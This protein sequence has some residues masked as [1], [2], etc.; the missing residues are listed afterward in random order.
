MSVFPVSNGLSMYLQ[1]KVTVPPSALWMVCGP[2]DI[3]FSP[4]V[5]V[6]SVQIQTIS[7]ISHNKTNIA[8]GSFSY[9][10][11]VNA[12]LFLIHWAAACFHAPWRTLCRLFLF[13]QSVS[14]R[15]NMANKISQIETN[16][17]KKMWE[18][19]YK[20]FRSCKVN[21]YLSRRCNKKL[22]VHGAFCKASF[23]QCL[24]YNRILYNTV[25]LRKNPTRSQLLQRFHADKKPKRF[26]TGAEK[27]KIKPFLCT[28]WDDADFKYWNNYL[29]K[30]NLSAD[31][32]RC[33]NWTEICL[34]GGNGTRYNNLVL[35]GILSVLFSTFLR[36]HIMLLFHFVWVCF[37]PNTHEMEQD[38]NK[39]LMCTSSPGD[40]SETEMCWTKASPD[41]DC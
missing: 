33:L 1:P 27:I 28:H 18:W 41:S 39:I 3:T 37:C 9:D 25:I 10:R 20:L 2:V 36:K 29:I 24:G 31:N 13:N 17:A 12:V 19:C 8:I 22:S 15:G 7:E 23:I 34:S 26:I 38:S 35:S 14:L 11:V 6:S 5:H 21:M 32:R 40:I 16:V 30:T 4:R